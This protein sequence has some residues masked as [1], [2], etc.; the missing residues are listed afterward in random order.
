MALN[1]KKSQD[2]NTSVTNLRK[3]TIIK[4]KVK[5]SAKTGKTV[6]KKLFLHTNFKKKG[7][8]KRR[9]TMSREVMQKIKVL[10]KRTKI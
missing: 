7:R 8:Q 6:A 1:T 2:K 4:Y 9:I 3:S 5:H 10:S